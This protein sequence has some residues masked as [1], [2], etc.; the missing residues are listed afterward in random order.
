MFKNM[1]LAAKIGMGF[2]LLVLIAMV[3]G[4]VAVFNM[5]RVQSQAVTI[6]KEYV[7]EVTL[8]SNLERNSLLTMYNMR[9]YGYTEEEQFYQS[10][11]KSLGDVDKTLGDV[12]AL[13][14]NAESLVKLKEDYPAVKSKV[15]EY[16]KL[17]EETKKVNAKLEEDRVAMDTAAAAYIQNSND[18]LA[19]QNEA[20]RADFNAGASTDK[21]DERLTKITLVNDVIDLGNGTRVG[22]F[23]AQATRDPEAYKQVMGNFSEIQKKLDELQ[24]ITRLQLNLDQIAEVRTQAANYE[25]AMSDFLDNWLKR[26]ELGKK[27]NDAAEAVLQGC[28]EIATAGAEGM[29]A[30]MDTAVSSLS[31]ANIVMIVGLLGALVIGIVIALFIT[32]SI[33]LPINRIIADLNEGAEQ[34]SSASG[35]VS[36]S[37]QQLAEGAS[38]QASSLEEISSSLEEMAS[39]TRQNAANADQA[40][41]LSQNAKESAE[42]GNLST[43]RLM[44]AMKLITSSAEQ[45]QKIIKTIDEIAFQTNLLALNAAVEAARAGE[46]GKG[47][48]VVAEEVRNLAQRAGEAARNTSELIEGSVTNTSNGSKIADEVAQALQDITAGARK[49]TELVA[50]IAAASKEQ[51]QGIDQVNVAV[52]QMDQIT[53]SNA[54][55]AEESA[56]AS[57]EMNSQAGQMMGVVE[58]LVSLVGATSQ[59]AAKTNGVGNQHKA[60]TPRH[61]LNFESISKVHVGGN[62]GKKQLVTHSASKINTRKA[63]AIIPLDGDDDFN[64]F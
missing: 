37:S 16:R 25:A 18:F 52:G 8:A 38:E 3:L 50:E 12:K 7:P 5:R 33:T 49:V 36:S 23:K 31:M 26:E 58:E 43:Q 51:A 27:R 40:N 35:Q 42:K 47:F 14:D 32:R 54:S 59:Q 4:A 11:E 39:M 15:D 22:N 61:H 44:E 46:A 13:L 48:A 34:V 60:E 62:G 2:G 56:S 17:A 20:M 55:N 19:S 21:L 30:R 64:E 41:N 29:T 57:E 10:A 28:E 53:Q 9:G 1:K 45:T 24:K 63:E 6:A